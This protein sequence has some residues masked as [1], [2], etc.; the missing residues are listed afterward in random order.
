MENNKIL[1]VERSG[2]KINTNGIREKS[3]TMRD[4]ICNREGCICIATREIVWHLKSSENDSPIIST[5][6]ARLCD[7]HST[8]NLWDIFYNRESWLILCDAITGMGRL[9][10]KKQF[11]SLH[12]QPIGTSR[13][14]MPNV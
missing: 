11:S 6:I 4:F 2:I 7:E 5:P 13:S 10:P 9:K 12:P 8:M 3:G 1:R 14:Q